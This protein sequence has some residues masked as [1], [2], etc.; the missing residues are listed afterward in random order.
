M[1]EHVYSAGSFVR[2][3]GTFQWLSGAIGIVDGATS[4]TGKPLVHF[5]NHRLWICDP[6][7]LE[8]VSEFE[9][10]FALLSAEMS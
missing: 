9:Y 4:L 7:E 8:F 10:W 2:F 3:K 1:I 5:V 6:D